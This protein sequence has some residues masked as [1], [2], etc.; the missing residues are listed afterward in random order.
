MN[1]PKNH[2]TVIHEQVIAAGRFGASRGWVPAT[3]GNFSARLDERHIVVTRSGRDKGALTPADLATISLDEPLPPGLSAEAP[4]HVARYRADPAIGAIYH[5]HSTTA[6]LASRLHAASATLLLQGWELQKAF[7]GVTSHT[8]ALTVPV[9]ANSQ[10]T[11]ALADDV[12]ARLGELP[13]QSLAPGYLLA[14][15]GLYAWGR[16]G[17]EALRHLEAF[18]VLLQLQ[19]DWERSQR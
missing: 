1:A 5:V 4:L 3:S 7:A 18:D 16:D 2:L 15:H 8:V 13:A 14:G 19:L 10:D 17:N 11:V 9:F 12:E 6:A